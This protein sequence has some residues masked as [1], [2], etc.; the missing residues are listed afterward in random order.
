LRSDINNRLLTIGLKGASF[1]R[2]DSN[3]VILQDL[4]KVSGKHARVR[5]SE[6]KFNLLDL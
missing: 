2:S 5:F 6:N 4:S 1:G 3:T